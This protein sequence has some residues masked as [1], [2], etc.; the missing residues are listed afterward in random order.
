MNK[1]D[2]LVGFKV[3]FNLLTETHVINTLKE[4]IGYP[5]KSL[6]IIL[7]YKKTNTQLFNI[8]SV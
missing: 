6:N 2:Y 1:F 8:V 3:L 5:W 4:M 7:K